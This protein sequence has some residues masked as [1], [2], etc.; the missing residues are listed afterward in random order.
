MPLPFE[1]ID[2]HIHLWDPRTTPRQVSPAMKLFGWSPA[3]L[4]WMLPKLFPRKALDFVG[5]VDVVVQLL[6]LCNG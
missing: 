1:I 2:A 5:N 6:P 3:L 4:H